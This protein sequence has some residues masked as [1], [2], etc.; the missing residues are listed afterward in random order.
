MDLTLSIKIDHI[1][2]TKSRPKNTHELKNSFH[3]DVQ[4]FCEFGHL[5]TIFFFGRW[6]IEIE[7]TY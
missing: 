5:R 3:C 7:V 4:L 6:H 1:S 2:K